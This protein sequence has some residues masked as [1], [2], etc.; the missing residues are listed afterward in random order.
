MEG[1]PFQGGLFDGRT[2]NRPLDSQ[3]LKGQG[4]RVYTLM[5]DVPGWHT[6]AEISQAVGAPE[7]SCSA[8]LRD[9]RK[10]RNGG[11]AVDRRPHPDGPRGL[12]QYRLRR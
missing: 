3:R 7:A 11:H 5:R 1:D 9:L 4:L 2:F 6:L 10:P 8:R 12:Y